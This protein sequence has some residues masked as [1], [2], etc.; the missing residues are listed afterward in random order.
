VA[1]GSGSF[2]ID[3]K[4]EFYTAL[5]EIVFDNSKQELSFVY[6]KGSEFKSGDY[7]IIILADTYEI[8][9]ATFNVR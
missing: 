6:D 8:G 2:K 5:Q 9:Q 4:E 1:R 3:G 7:K